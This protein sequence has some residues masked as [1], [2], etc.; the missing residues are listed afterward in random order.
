MSFTVPHMFPE[1]LLE[2]TKIRVMIAAPDES[3]GGER[4]PAL[5]IIPTCGIKEATNL[6]QD[7]AKA[8]HHT[9]EAW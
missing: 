5:W 1:L 3:A 7:A 6:A 4:G 8:L 2:G 9:V